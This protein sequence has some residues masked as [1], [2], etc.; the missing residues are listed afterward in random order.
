MGLR[1]VYITGGVKKKMIQLRSAIEELRKVRGL[2]SEDEKRLERVI[3]TMR[4]VSSSEQEEEDD[5]ALAWFGRVKRKR[6]RS[7]SWNSVPG[8]LGEALRCADD[9]SLFDG[10]A[11]DEASQGFV[12]SAYASRVFRRELVDVEILGHFTRIVDTEYGDNPYHNRLH[13]VDVMQAA[14]SMLSC[15][16]PIRDALCDEVSHLAV[17]FAAMIHDLKHPG[18]N[19]SFL[20]ETQHELALR[21]SDDSTLERMHLAQGFELMQKY[22]WL[23]VTSKD[24]RRAFRSTVIHC[25]LATDLKRSNHYLSVFKGHCIDD[26][27]DK[28]SLASMVVKL[29]DV[30]HPA[31][32]RKTH[33]V[34]TRRIMAEFF[35]QGELEKRKGI[36][37]LSPLCDPHSLD[38]PK[39]QRGF[40]DFVTRPVLD[41]LDDFSKRRQQKS[42]P[43]DR[44]ENFTMDAARRLLEGNYEFWAGGHADDEET[45]TQVAEEIRRPFL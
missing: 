11:L 26:E 12:I 1:V 40:I 4:S 15:R 44:T 43:S 5:S 21:Y 17:L 42:S 45:A 3:D 27:D 37:T 39:S 18:V 34:W 35:R 16:G 36:D 7:D 41:A 10:D 22:D 14:H 13:G 6:K 29:A 30:S 25:V 31:R 19:E 33:L 9:W 28:K 38:I 2:R 32:P 23:K 24:F 20:I 8:N